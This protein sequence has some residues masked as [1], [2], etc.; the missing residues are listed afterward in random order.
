MHYL[1][2]NLVGLC[3]KYFVHI[4]AKNEFVEQVLVN[5]PQYKI[6]RKSVQ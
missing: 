4:V 2:C 5:S 3:V 1:K 6:S